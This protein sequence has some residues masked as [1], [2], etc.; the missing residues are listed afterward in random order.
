MTRTSLR[1]AV[2]HFPRILKTMKS[3]ANLEEIAERELLVPIDLETKK[4]KINHK[5]RNRDN[6]DTS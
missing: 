2:R 1:G 4:A 6:D 3:T 5:R